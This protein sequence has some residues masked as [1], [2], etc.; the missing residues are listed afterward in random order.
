MAVVAVAIVAAIAI[1]H[2][3]TAADAVT[4]IGPVTAVISSLVAAYFGIRT[5]TMTQQKA[6]E[7]QAL[8]NE[9]EA[10]RRRPLPPE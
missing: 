7:S 8:R 9:E 5:G 3:D 2:Y 4:V 10:L 1:Y 6:N